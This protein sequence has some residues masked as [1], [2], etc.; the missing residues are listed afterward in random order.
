[1]KKFRA[2]KKPAKDIGHLW[3]S[4]AGLGGIIQFSTNNPQLSALLLLGL[5]IL[6][7]NSKKDPSE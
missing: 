3:Q 1:M 2:K 5:V 6:L 4:L 7:L